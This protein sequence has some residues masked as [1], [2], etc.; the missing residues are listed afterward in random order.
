MNMSS[1]SFYRLWTRLSSGRSL[2]I[3]KEQ[4][5]NQKQA[6]QWTLQLIREEERSLIADIPI[7][8]FEIEFL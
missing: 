2:S 1:W 7:R 8:A 5:R 4:S 6:E 3:T